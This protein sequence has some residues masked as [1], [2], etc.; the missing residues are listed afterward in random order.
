MALM[1]ALTLAGLSTLTAV[2]PLQGQIE[3]HPTGVNVNAQG[4]TSVFITFTNLTGYV[5]AEA[6]WCGEVVPASPD[7]GQRCDESTI[8]GALPIRFARTRASGVD[9]LTDVMTIPASVARRAY[10]A[11]T[12][13]EDSRFFYV[14]RFV[15]PTGLGP[16]QYVAVTCRLTGGGARTPLA[17]LDVRLAFATQD[18]VLSLSEQEDPPPL[19][20][21]IHYNGTG[22]LVG[23]WEVIR[24]G[25]P[26]PTAFDLLTEASLPVEVRG[27]QQRFLELERFNVFLPPTGHV[28][29]QGPDLSRLPKDVAGLYQVVLRVEASADREGDSDVLGVGAGAVAGF[30]LPTLRYVVG[31]G[32]RIGLAGT[33]LRALDPVSEARVPEAAPTFYWTHTAG[34]SFY[35]IDIRSAEDPGSLVQALVPSSDAGYTAPPWLRERLGSAALEWR[36]VSLDVAGDEDQTT[37]WR[38]VFLDSEP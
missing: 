14:R 9:A 13:G 6:I 31:D 23:R 30:P 10:Q 8:Y 36:V 3:R 33:R 11:A 28:T 16:D 27:T 5:A 4:P 34:A 1:R 17:L 7:L 19:T 12:R 32:G 22:A 18:P 25:D 20:A 24:P 37:P 38:A 35:R 2:S 26:A 21:D 29:V 15:D